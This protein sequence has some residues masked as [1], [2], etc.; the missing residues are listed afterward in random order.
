MSEI[1]EAQALAD[2]L[3]EGGGHPPALEPEVLETIYALKPDLAPAHQLTVEEVLD[4]LVEGPLVDPAIA[5]A[6]AEW[7]N[8]DPGTPPPRL[9]PIGVVE[10]AYALRPDLAPAPSISID[11][12]L[13]S[14]ETGPLVS[15]PK[16]AT[17]VRLVAGSNS[18]HDAQTHRSGWAAMRSPRVWGAMAMAAAVLLTVRPD[19]AEVLNAPSPYES[20]AIADVPVLHEVGF[21]GEP[22]VKEKAEAPEATER[23]MAEDN[24]APSRPPAAAEPTRKQRHKSAPKASPTRRSAAPAPAPKPASTP[25][26][27]P[28][29]PPPVLAVAENAALPPPM[30][31]AEAAPA[32]DMATDEDG[33]MS[34]EEYRDDAE[35]RRM[36]TTAVPRTRAALGWAQPESG[37]TD[38]FSAASA[39]EDDGA[40]ARALRRAE[41]LKRE[42]QF[43][44][45]LETV[46]NA[47]STHKTNRRLKI[48]LLRL[49]VAILEAMGRETDA[50]QAQKELSIELNSR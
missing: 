32:M 16:D 41:Q 14:L 12:V 48:K 44:A 13:N 17:P 40:P 9:L 4:S 33:A 30:P 5:K 11:D 18:D 26:P 38:T 6:L 1:Q 20:D 50:Q 15:A 22:V 49:K 10:T 8:S 35:P 43:S 31:Q 37:G 21:S 46:D 45:A 24:A 36:P 25:E 23:A 47:L 39:P 7:L 3:D 2:W 28:I 27:E 29:P 19:S 34:V 42:G